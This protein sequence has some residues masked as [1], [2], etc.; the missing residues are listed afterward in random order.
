MGERPIDAGSGRS[1]GSGRRSLSDCRSVATWRWPWPPRRRRSPMRS[2]SPV[3]RPSQPVA[4]PTSSGP[5]PSP[6]TALT[7]WSSTG[8][9]RRSSGAATPTAWAICWSPRAL[10]IGALPRPFARWQASRSCQDRGLSG[11]RGPGQRQPRRRDAARRAW[12]PRPDAARPAGH[13]ARGVPPLEPRPAGRVHG[14]DPLRD[15]RGRRVEAG[16]RSGGVAA[17][18]IRTRRGQ[19]KPCLAGLSTG[20]VIRKIQNAV[21]RGRCRSERLIR[22]AARPAGLLGTPLVPVP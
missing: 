20:V 19:A 8:S 11:H 14:G 3:R 16:H 2:S 1:A 4:G 10:P 9:V 22:A 13:A 17:R 5:W 15:R 6:T 7:T 12:F 21:R 18:L